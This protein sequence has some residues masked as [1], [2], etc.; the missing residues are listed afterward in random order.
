MKSLKFTWNNRSWNTEKVKFPNFW[1]VFEKLSN[2]TTQKNWRSKKKA[3]LWIYCRVQLYRNIPTWSFKFFR[4]NCN[5]FE[6]PK[7]SYWNWE[8]STWTENFRILGGVCCPSFQNG[9]AFDQI[10]IPH[11][12]HSDDMMELESNRIQ[13]FNN[14]LSCRF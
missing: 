5:F 10:I 2:S 4:A 7:F 3:D 11:F 14:L 12:H 1:L 13:V 9:P 8:F 6:C